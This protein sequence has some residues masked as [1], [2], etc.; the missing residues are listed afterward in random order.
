MEKNCGEALDE[1]K[2][3][4]RVSAGNYYTVLSLFSF[5]MLLLYCIRGLIDSI[6]FVFIGF[7]ASIDDMP[8]HIHTVVWFWIEDWYFLSAWRI[9]RYVVLFHG[10]Y[11]FLKIQREQYI[12]FSS[13]NARR[14]WM[15]VYI[16]SREKNCLY[17]PCVSIYFSSRKCIYC[18]LYT[19]RL[20]MCSIH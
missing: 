14:G 4:F 19:K 5:F 16:Y 1:E 15:H 7:S 8:L 18:I 9:F 17:N 11:T 13:Y 2:K 6:N 3:L 12:Y 10:T 20:N